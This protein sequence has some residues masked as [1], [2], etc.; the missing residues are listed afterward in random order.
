[1]QR[2]LP[3]FCLKRLFVR[4]DFPRL[5]CLREIL[6][7]RASS[8]RHYDTLCWLSFNFQEPTI[9][10]ID[11]QIEVVNWS[12]KN[13]LWCLIWE[14]IS[15]WDIILLMA[16]FAYNNSVNR[17]TWR[18]PFEVVIGVKPCLPI[19]SPLPNEARPSKK[20]EDFAWHMKDVHDEVCKQ[21][22]RSNES[23][24][25]HA[26]ARRHLVKFN[27][28]DM[29]MAQMKH[30]QFLVGAYKKLHSRSARPFNILKKIISNSYVL[31]LPSEM[32]ISS[33]SMLKISQFIVGAIRMNHLKNKISS[34][35][36][37]L[38]PA[39]KL[40]MSWCL[41]SIKN[42]GYQRF[43]SHVE[44]KTSLWCHVD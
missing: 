27:E 22:A 11:C 26:D 42:G 33:H 8:R 34:F 16:E 37:F 2:R 15:I 40:K 18:S 10:K 4:M 3:L 20:A 5:Y 7:S 30:G 21:I 41:V 14:R 9:S 32:N 38:L 25:Q 39:K 1:M 17:A 43:F 23:F 12:L 6:S 13:L 28:G 24:R 35:P 19:E 44:R 29:V 36:W 31:I